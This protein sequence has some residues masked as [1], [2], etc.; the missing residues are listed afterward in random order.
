MTKA[1]PTG[2]V[3]CRT[4]TGRQR[5]HETIGAQITECK[6]IV[7]RYGI[8]LLRY[9][10]KKDG[11]LIDDG[12]S[13]SLLKGRTFS[14]LIDD[15][16]ARRV[17]PDYLIVFSLERVGRPDKSSRDMNKLVTSATDNARIK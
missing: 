9:G 3:Y 1:A 2:I 14:S 13:G 5:D 16:E 17:K 12:V 7:E 4:S 6:R 11:W 10:L 15:L 8:R